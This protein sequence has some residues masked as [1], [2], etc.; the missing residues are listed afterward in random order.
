MAPK[1]GTNDDIPVVSEKVAETENDKDPA[2]IRRNVRGGG[3]DQGMKPKSDKI[4]PI[5]PQS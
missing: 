5:F 2:T 4:V 3:S 1:E